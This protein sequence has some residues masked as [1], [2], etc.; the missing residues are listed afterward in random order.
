MC[1]RIAEGVI[2]RPCGHF[3][4]TGITAIVDCSSSRCRKSIRHGDRCNCAKRGCIDYWGPD[5][6]KVIAHIDE[7][8]SPCRFPP[9]EPA[10]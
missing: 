2:Y 9:R 8:C 5:V 1:R 3:R 6:Q 10:I 4:R 7:L